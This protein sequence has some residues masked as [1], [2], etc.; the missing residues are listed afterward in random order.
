MDKKIKNPRRIEG[1]KKSKNEEQS[2]ATPRFCSI[3]VFPEFVL[4][5]FNL[6]V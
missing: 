4:H 3:H 1:I 6:F 5:G 2:R